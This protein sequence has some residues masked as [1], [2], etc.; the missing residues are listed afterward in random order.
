[1]YVNHQ[2]DE[3]EKYEKTVKILRQM[4]I[5][6]LSGF[7]ELQISNVYILSNTMVEEAIVQICGLCWKNSPLLS[8]FYS[9]LICQD[10]G[11]RILAGKQ[12][13]GNFHEES[14]FYFKPGN[15]HCEK[16]ILVLMITHSYSD[17]LDLGRTPFHDINLTY[18]LSTTLPFDYTFILA[19]TNP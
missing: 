11:V 12:I 14:D 9:G 10:Q 15:Y 19:N 6:A 17:Q 2:T 4:K 1:M 8:L 18:T 3:G 5:Y 13:Q 7:V 16:P